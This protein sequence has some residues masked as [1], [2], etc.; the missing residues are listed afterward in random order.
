MLF[1][2]R[3]C[4]WLSIDS[5]LRFKLSRVV[6]SFHANLFP[7]DRI[8]QEIGNEVAIFSPSLHYR[9]IERPSPLM[10]IKLE[11]IARSIVTPLTRLRL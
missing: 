6:A 3:N 10:I 2:F 8:S 4:L 5:H 1:Y 9:I 7:L 11:F